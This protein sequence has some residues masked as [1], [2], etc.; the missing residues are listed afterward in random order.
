M[1]HT[2]ILRAIKNNYKCRDFYWK[3][4]RIDHYSKYK[5]EVWKPA[6]TKTGIDEFIEVSNYG[7]VRNKETEHLFKNNTSKGYVHVGIT[8]KNIKEPFSVHRLVAQSFLKNKFG[9]K[10]QVNHKDKNITNNH[11]DNLE[12]LDSGSHSLKDKAVSVTEICSDNS[13]IVHNSILEAGKARNVDPGQISSAISSKIRCK[14]S[15]WI[16]TKDFNEDKLEE[17]KLKNL[18]KR[19]SN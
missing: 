15:H 19:K 1:F 11:V 5:D 18:K 10:A 2:L 7:R 13:I 14:N 3:R 4:E 17:I 12:W 9:K 8:Y 16:R 6:N